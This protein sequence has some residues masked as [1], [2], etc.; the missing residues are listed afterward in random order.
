MD[1]PLSFLTETKKKKILHLTARSS[2]CRGTRL[3]GDR[4]RSTVEESVVGVSVAVN[5]EVGC[6]P[7]GALLSEHRCGV[8][9]HEEGLA[10]LE[11]VVVVQSIGIGV[12]L[13]GS[14]VHRELAVILAFGLKHAGKLE[15]SVGDRVEACLSADLC[16]LGVGDQDLCNIKNA[17]VSEANV[18]RLALKVLLVH[19]PCNTFAPEHLVVLH[20]L[21]K[22]SVAVDVRE[23]EFTSGAECVV[24]A[25]EDSRLVGAEVDHAVADNDVDGLEG[26]ARLNDL[27]NVS[28]VEFEVRLRIPKLRREVHDVLACNLN[29]LLRHVNALDRSVLPNQVR[30]KVAVATASRAKVQNVE[31]LNAEGKRGAASVELLVDLRGDLLE[32][33]QHHRVRAARG[34]AGRGLEILAGGEHLAVVLLH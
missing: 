32:G 10:L 11:L 25:L 19:R 14:L 28:V 2:S 24:R 12:T 34:S 15:E 22:A 1:T 16:K 29:L 18:A 7:R 31:A 4:N 23:V 8:S 9:A 30:R 27:L 21:G 20:G 17:G 3:R 5:L 13:N 26:D 33:L 6:E